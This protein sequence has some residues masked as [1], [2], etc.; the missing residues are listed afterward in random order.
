MKSLL[1]YRVLLAYFWIV[2]CL[3][4][5]KVERPS[6]V[7]SDQLMGDILFD[8]HKAKAMGDE[9][10]YQE[11]YKKALYIE[12][13]FRKHGVTQAEFDS[14]M[15]WFARHPD[16]FSKVYEQVKE[17]LVHER[18]GINRLIAL[19]DNKPTESQP[20]DSIDVWFWKRVYNLTGM[21]FDNKLTFSLPSDVNFSQRDTLVWSVRFS[22]VGGDS[23]LAPTM[24]MQILYS[25]DTLCSE[26]KKIFSDG[27][28]TLS[29]SADSLGDLKEVRGFIYYPMGKSVRSLVLDSIS[30]MRYHATDSLKTASLQP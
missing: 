19:R 9:V 13:V 14:S 18:D 29:L 28:Q 30:L 1:S 24:A 15:V 26:P 7:F 6:E 23:L 12:S 11:S 5:C 21:P 8:Y 20:G 3:V 27:I 22:Q 2:F 4:G 10:S 17:R 25:K 16:V